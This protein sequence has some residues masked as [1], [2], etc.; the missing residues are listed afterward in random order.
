MSPSLASYWTTPVPALKSTDGKSGLILAVIAG[1]QG[2]MVSRGAD[3][4]ATYGGNHNG[5]TVL[6]GGPAGVYGDINTQV[7][8]SLVRAESVAIPLTLLLLLLVFGSVVAAL[9]PLLIGGCAIVGTFA[10]LAVLGR[11][12]DVSVF[13]INL[14]T[15]L[16]LGLGID[17]GLL[18]VARFREQLA[19]GNDVPTAVARTVATAGRTILFSAAAVACALATLMVFPLF[20]LSSFGYAGVGVVVIAAVSALTITPA[21]LALL[22]H[23]G[24]EGQAPDRRHRP[25]LGLPVLEAGRHHGVPSPGPH[26]GAG[27]ARA[28]GGRVA[29][30][31]HPL[32]TARPDGA[33][34]RGAEPPG[35]RTVGRAVPEPVGRHRPG[36]PGRSGRR[37]SWRPPTPWSSPESGT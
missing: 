1:D 25:R 8:K 27:P 17:Y 15:A 12:T 11:I 31:G 4:I 33:A 5:L 21:A 18:I 10:E 36:D 13:A 29:D 2:T 22:G 30:A 7:T 23:P 37:Q 19:A 34:A 35:R 28:A 32:R 6:S 9:L 3:L 24:G 16:G 20:F 14:T 26:R